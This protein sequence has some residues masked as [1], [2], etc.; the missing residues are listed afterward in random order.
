MLVV[1]LHFAPR[2]LQNHNISYQDMKDIIK[3]YSSRVKQVF[4]YYYFQKVL[5]GSTIDTDRK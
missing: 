4:N 1:K 2:F 3:L 5:D